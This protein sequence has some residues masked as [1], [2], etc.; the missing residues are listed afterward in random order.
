MAGHLPDM[1]SSTEY[2]ATLLVIV[3]IYLKSLF[4]YYENAFLQ[5]LSHEK[6]SFV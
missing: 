1:D 5:I 3:F 4:L 6:T 2:I